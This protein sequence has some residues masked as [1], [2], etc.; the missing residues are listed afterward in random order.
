MSFL[1]GR[2]VK[3]KPVLTLLRWG[4]WPG[5]TVRVPA[6]A[7]SETLGKRNVPRGVV[8]R[9]LRR[10]APQIPG[11]SLVSQTLKLAN[12]EASEQCHNSNFPLACWFCVN[13]D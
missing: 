12:I 2:L 5:L 8:T 9:R 3:E 10:K 6:L 13:I 4:R 7:D 1:D 11:V